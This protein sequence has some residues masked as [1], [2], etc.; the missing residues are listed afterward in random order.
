MEAPGDQLF[1]Q[2]EGQIQQKIIKKNKGNYVEDLLSKIPQDIQ[3]DVAKELFKSLEDEQKKQVAASVVK[4]SP[5]DVQVNIAKES[6]NSLEDKQK[7]QVAASVVKGSSQDVQV[8]IAK[9][10]SSNLSAKE[11]EELA[12]TLLPDRRVINQIWLTVIRSLSLA[13][14]I[15][16]IFLASSIFLTTNIQYVQMLLIVFTTIIA[17][18]WGL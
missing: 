11:R 12:K 5:Q 10:A 15:S 8:D 14:V 16:V 13:I 4:E 6:F 17:F 3:V 1:E 18:F 2:K 9:E 7:K